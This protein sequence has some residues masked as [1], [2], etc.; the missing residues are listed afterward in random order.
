M[1]IRLALKI[2]RVMTEPGGRRPYSRGRL[3]VAE[4]TLECRR[5]GTDDRMYRQKM[6]WTEIRRWKDELKKETE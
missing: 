4:T 1:R 5:R 6:T 2:W 3:D